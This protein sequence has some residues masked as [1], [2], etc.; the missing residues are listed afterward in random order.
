MVV[1]SIIGPRTAERNPSEIIVLAFIFVSLAIGVVDYLK[2]DP[3]GIMLIMFTLIPAVPFI[4]TL[5]K[6]EEEELEHETVMGSKTIRRHVSVVLVLLAFFIGITLGF[7]FWHLF[8]EQTDPVKAAKFF[9]PQLSELKRIQSLGSQ[10]SGQFLEA[11]LSPVIGNAIGPGSVMNFIFFQNLRVLVLV[12][13]GS[14]VYG[15]GSVFIIIWNASII[16][17]FLS[18][19]ASKYVFNEAPQFSLI[20]GLSYGI[21]GLIPH[22]TFEAIAYLTGALAGGILSSALTRKVWGTPEFRPIFIDVLKLIG[23]SVL[24]VFIGAVVESATF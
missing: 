4:L 10:F 17:V 16:G 5:F 23:V 19:I 1:E 13:L 14:L 8:L 3:P 20:P 21:L 22:G 9:D 24:L 11:D 18:T 6:L 7:T 12:I 15:A 2:I